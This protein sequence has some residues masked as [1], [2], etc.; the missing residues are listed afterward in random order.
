MEDDRVGCLCQGFVPTVWVRVCGFVPVG[1]VLEK[2]EIAEQVDSWAV[3]IA[4][5]DEAS[6][7]DGG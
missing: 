3:A 5:W 1:L 6:R 7:Q 4:P 2:V